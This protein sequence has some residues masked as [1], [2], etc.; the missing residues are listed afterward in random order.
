MNYLVIGPWYHGGASGDDSPLGPFSFKGNPASYFRRSILLPFLNEQ[1]KEGSPKAN[2]PPVLAYKTGTDVWRNY[3]AWP[4]ACESGCSQTMLPLYLKSGLRLAFTPPGRSETSYAEYISDPAQ[5]VPYRAR[6]IP[7][8]YAPSST[9]WRWLVDDQRPFSPRS[10]TL[11]YKTDIL[12]Q[13][14]SLSGQPIAN[15]FASTSGTDCDFVVKLIDVYPD[16]YPSQPE[17]AGYQLMISADILRGR[18][19]K[20]ATHPSP[21]PAGKIENFR[22]VLPAATHVFLPGHRIMVQIQSSWFPLYDRNPQ[23][24]VDNIFT[25]G[26]EDYR[27]AVQR[28]Y[29]M[30]AAASSIELPIAQEAPVDE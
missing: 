15:L 27:K 10:D 29:Q 4:L 28:I 19:R 22:W 5:P 8:P 21:I 2:T 18:Y 25:A 12:S 20:D 14:V 23:T 6:P 24:Y 3:N 11:T 16:H 26:P 7:P 30:D 1:L 17:L 9:W 13:P